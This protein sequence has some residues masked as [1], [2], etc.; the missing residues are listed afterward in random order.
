MKIKS[1]NNFKTFSFKKG[2]TSHEI[3]IV[4][5]LPNDY[6]TA[7]ADYL[8]NRY[9]INSDFKGCKTVAWCTKETA[10]IMERAGFKLP[11]KVV[12][13]EIPPKKGENPSLG[14]YYSSD[15]TVKINALYPQFRN[16]KAQNGLEASQGS[17]H[18]STK[19]FL[20]TYLHEFSHA[21]H[22]N[23]MCDKYDKYDAMYKWMDMTDTS[24]DEFIVGPLNSIIREKFSGEYA[25]KIIDVLIPPKNGTYARKNL[26]EYFAEKNA[27][28]V[29]ECL[30]DDYSKKIFGTLLKNIRHTQ[31]AGF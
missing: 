9:G 30:G 14:Q 7:T 31:K 20:D 17:F 26:C 19:H 29:A 27:R 13:E 21:A 23:N 11:K 16:I 22:F 25:K 5:N 4:K 2:L 24:T 10:E 18:P 6:C 8:K 12:F 1:I 15:D 3:D 28:T